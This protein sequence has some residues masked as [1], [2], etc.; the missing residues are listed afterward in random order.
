MGLVF[1]LPP[2]TH[3]NLFFLKS[4]VALKVTSFL[5]S[6]SLPFTNI[7]TRTFHPQFCPP[8]SS[9]VW[10]ISTFLQVG[11]QLLRVLILLTESSLVTL[12]LMFIPRA[13]PYIMTL[14]TETPNSPFSCCHLLTTEITSH[15]IETIGLCFWTSWLS[16]AT[17]LVRP[18]MSDYLMRKAK[19]MLIHHFKRRIF[20]GMV[21]H[22]YIPTIQETGTKLFYIEIVLDQSYIWEF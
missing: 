8:T 5:P 22:T 16:L 15:L 14:E 12:A 7:F 17:I 13:K 2:P 9:A 10:V 4:P 20:P 6:P 18:R 19:M 3:S 21:A 1:F 11:H